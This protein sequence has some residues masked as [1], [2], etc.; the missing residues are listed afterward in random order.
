MNKN[1]LTGLLIVAISFWFFNSPTY[2]KII[3]KPYPAKSTVQAVKPIDVDV[4]KDELVDK[5]VIKGDVPVVI[6]EPLAV[7]EDSSA[8]SSLDSNSIVIPQVVFDTITMENKLLKLKVSTKGGRI[9]SAKVKDYKYAEGFPKKGELVELFQ[10][11]NGALGGLSINDQSYDSLNFKYDDKSAGGIYRFV[12]RVN[13][14]DV[15][16]EYALEDSSYYINYKVKSSLLKNVSSKLI[17]DAGISESE[18][19]TSLSFKY[20]PR[21]VSLYSNKKL[22]KKHLKAAGSLTVSDNYDWVAVNSKY[23][24]VVVMPT[25]VEQAEV[26]LSGDIID[27]GA[28]AGA[29][30]LNYMYSIESSVENG[31]DEYTIFLGPNKI[32]DLKVAGKHLENLMFRGYGWFFGANIWFPKLCSAVLWLMGMFYG[33]THDYGIAIIILT[34]LLKLI[35]FPLSQSSMKSMNKMKEI[36]PEIK[37]IQDKYKSNP[38]AVQQKIMEFYKEQGINPLAGMGAG[39]LPMFAQMPIMISLFIVLRKSI[40]LR[41]ETTNIV[42]W[43]KDLSQPEV[44][45]TLPFSLPIYGSNVAILPIIMAV[46]MY[47]QNKMTMKDPNQKSMV[48]MMPIM[49]LLMFNN[50]PSGLT[51]YFVFSSIFQIAQQ[52]FVDK[53]V[54]KVSIVTVK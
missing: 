22:S 6:S 53:G 13:G 2:Y 47:F 30:N 43:L 42:F 39:C 11:S 3:G 20:S 49:M 40:E 41:G 37:K 18:S 16:K 24:S 21:V 35:T 8:D 54:S 7:V 1:T 38:Q 19:K 48:L 23:F 26:V 5:P 50:F 31:L 33:F 29:N 4:S 9:I 32:S 51:L 28:K 12:A 27:K 36:Q 46:L 14:V 25:K 10:N 34:L 52:W 44:V 15:I 17:F 45:F